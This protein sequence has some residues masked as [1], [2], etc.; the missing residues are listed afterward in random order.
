M[1][2]NPGPLEA[3]GT[4]IEIDARML[5]SLTSPPSFSLEAQTL[6]ARPPDRPTDLR[7]LCKPARGQEN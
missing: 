6:A 3:R 5:S 1:A 2:T 7:L 4:M